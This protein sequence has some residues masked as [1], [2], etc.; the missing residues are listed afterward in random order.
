MTQARSGTTD[1]LIGRRMGLSLMIGITVAWL[2]PKSAGGVWPGVLWGYVAAALTFSL[3]LLFTIAQADAAR[4]K[5]YVH[6]HD[7]SRSQGDVIAVSAALASLAG[8]A[9]LLSGEGRAATW[10]PG[11]T[12]LTVASGWL[13]IH[14]VYT[15]RYARHYYLAEPGCIAFE[16]GEPGLPDFAYLAFTLGMTYQVSDTDLRTPAVRRIVLF[17]TL[18]SYLFGTV[19]LGAMINLVI[20]MAM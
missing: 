18:L 14:T 17:H 19:I 3:P 5:A 15:V 16:S 8:I 11:L 9:L 4:T 7:A 12:F 1:L 6:G 2:M 13:T 10:G 20:A